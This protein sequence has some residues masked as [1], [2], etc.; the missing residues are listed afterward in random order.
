[1]SRYYIPSNDAAFD[2]WLNNLVGYVL[3]GPPVWPHIPA[4]EAEAYRK[5]AG[6]T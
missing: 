5:E 1:M 2:T 6:M 4:A 3:A